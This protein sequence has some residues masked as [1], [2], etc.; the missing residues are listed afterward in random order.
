MGLFDLFKK[1][2]DLG[3]ADLSVLKVDMHSHLIPGID[4]GSQNMDQTIAMLA[5]F[6]SFGYQKI[7]TTP[8]VMS[9]Y[10]KNTTDIIL[11]GLEAVQ[12]TAAKLNLS[13]EINA[14]AE[15]Y[16]DENFMS[17]IK[18]KDILT[19]GDSYVLFE[20]AF[21]NEPSNIN[22]LIFDL[23]SAGYTPVLAHFERYMYWLGNVEKARS[24][25]EN[26]VKIQMNLN[27]L[28]GH[29]GP[30][31]KKQAIALIDNELID[32]IAS[33]C[34]RIEHLMLLEKNLSSVHLHKALK[35]PLLNQSLI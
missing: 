28:T 15:Y 27:S 14:A 3:P 1:R 13:I 5:K 11:T 26:G 34:H 4:D 8:H 12:E 7:I 30:D 21:M 35:L 6:E 31:V 16:Y 24:L 29:Y 20:F 17:L 32:F 33:D 25:R 19:F 2:V 18:K 22:G 23:R 9:D 10:Y